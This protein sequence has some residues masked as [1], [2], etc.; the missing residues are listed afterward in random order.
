MVLAPQHKKRPT[1]AHQKRHGRHHHTEKPQYLKTYWPYLPLL[2]LAAVVN[3]L[4]DG[5]PADTL[6]TSASGASRLQLWTNTSYGVTLAVCL[7]VLVC[8]AI[9]F[10]RHAKAWHRVF[11][12]GEAFVLEHRSLDLLLVA[13]TLVGLL[14]TKAL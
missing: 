8:G 6:G 1:K 11:V 9:V 7:A 13:V 4:L 3:G 2:A 12:K 10:T 14:A 5:H